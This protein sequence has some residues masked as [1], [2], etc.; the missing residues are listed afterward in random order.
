MTEEVKYSSFRWF[1]LAT[2]VVSVATSS[3]SLISPA[4]L[5]ETIE[6]SGV[7]PGYNAGHLFYLMMV[8]FNFFVAVACIGGGFFLDR[9][10]FNKVYIFG[11]SLICLGEFLVP[12]IGNTMWGM[13]A[14]RMLEGFGTGP[15]MSAGASIAANYFP[16][17]ER[18]MVN[19]FVGFSVMTGI[20]IGVILVPSIAQSTG[21]WMSALHNIWPIGILGIIMNIIVAFGPKPPA[22]QELKL[23]VESKSDLAACFKI[24][25]TYFLIGFV[26]LMSWI[27]QTYNDITPNY[28]TYTPPKGLGVAAS[29]MAPSTYAFMAAA[30]LTGWINAILFKRNIKPHL[31]VAFLLGGLLTL[32]LISGSVTSDKMTLIIALCCMTFCYGFVNPLSLGYVS[33]NYPQHVTGRL[34]GIAQGL[35]IV[36]GF[37]GPL[38]TAAALTATD[39]Y[40]LPIIILA[41]VCFAGFFV[42]LFAPFKAGGHND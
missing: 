4:P 1:I 33:Q 19:G 38:V 30:V 37:C 16:Y 12:V 25:Q 20:S 13:L 41:C 42:A 18:P 17:K 21:S 28:L 15:I 9:F 23:P 27:F 40:T 36:G 14:V 2:M 6:K 35:G 11:I 7:F 8:S 31:I 29:L 10:G 34:G 3:L 39:R 22:V 26:F 24:P 32:T 5:F